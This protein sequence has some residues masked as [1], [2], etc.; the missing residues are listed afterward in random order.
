MAKTNTG[1]KW[2]SSFHQTKKKGGVSTKTGLVTIRLPKDVL[3]KIRLNAA[4]H[5]VPVSEYLRKLVV[6]QVA[7]KR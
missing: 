2:Y 7:R 3:N 1:E 6:T 5:S 4:R